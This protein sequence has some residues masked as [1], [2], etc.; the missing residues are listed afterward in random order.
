MGDEAYAIEELRAEICSAIMSAET[1]VP[2]TQSH[3]DNHASYLR[4]WIKAVASD[5][6]V[7]FSA[8]KD[9]EL[10]AEYM[11]VLAK[12][13]NAMDAHKEWIQDYDQTMEK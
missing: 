13:R 11:L 4:S 7:I 9:A 6:M 3:I 5:P 1:G 12:N 10:M 8:A 2:T